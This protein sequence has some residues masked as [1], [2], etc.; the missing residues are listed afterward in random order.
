MHSIFPRFLTSS[1]TISISR[2]VFGVLLTFL[3]ILTVTEAAEKTLPPIPDLTKGGELTRHNAFLVGPAG[4][5]SWI[6][7]PRQRSDDKK[8]IRQFQVEAVD[9]G[10]PADGILAKGD[11]IIGADGSGA[12]TVPLFDRHPE[13]GIADAI[14]EAEARN[15]A[16]LKLLR[17]RKGK[18]ET[19]TLTLET[20]GAYSDTAPYNCPKSKRILQKCVKAFYEANEPGEGGLGILILLAADDP[21]N[22]DSEKYQARAKEWAHKLIVT[23]ID[24]V[25]GGAWQISYTLISLT[26]YYLKTKD[27]EVFPT[28]QFYAQRFAN[29]QSWFGTTGHRFSE[30]QSDGSPNGL[31]AGY[32][33]I[34]AS[35]LAGFL[36]MNLAREAGVKSAEVDAA[37]RRADTFLGSY[38]FRSGIPYG[39]HPFWIDSKSYDNNGKHATAAFA[40]ALQHKRQ[41]EARWYAKMATAASMDRYYAH[42]GPY[43]AQV[44]DPLGAAVGGEKAANHHFNQIRWHLDLNRSWDGTIHYRGKTPYPGWADAA[45]SLLTYA[46]PLR[47]L[48]I[49]G[50]GHRKSFH[51]TD[52]EMA[53]VRATEKFNASSMSSKDLVAALSN[54]A[55]PDR[56][57]AVKELALRAKD[58]AVRSA[59]LTQLHTL[60]ANKKSQ[61]LERA[62]ACYALSTILDVSSTKVLIDRLSDQDRHVR[63]V[64]AKGLLDFPREDVMPHVNTILDLAATSLKPTFPLVEGDPIQFAHGAL[65]ELL[66]DSKKGLLKDS[67]EGIDRD[68]LWAAARAISNT[69]GGKARSSL[70]TLY[71]QLSRE[72]MLE[73]GE[74]IVE[75][76][77]VRAPA[78]SMFAKGIIKAGSELFI[79]HSIAEGVHLAKDSDQVKYLKNYAGSVLA[80]D[81]AEDIIEWLGEMGLVEGQKTSA[82]VDAISNDTNPKALTKMKLIHS[83]T[84]KD[85][86]L[87]LPMNKT[88]LQVK[89]TNYARR[90]M[91]DTTYT[92]RKVYGV[93]E[94][95]FS[96][97]S[98]SDSKSTTV[99]F[100]DL[101]PGEYR[102]EVTMSDTLGYNVVRD[103]VDVTLFDKS[104]QLPV[105]QTPNTRLNTLKAIPGLP[106]SI[107]ILGGN[108]GGV[109]I[110]QEPLHGKVSTIDSKI[111]YVAN[112]GYTGTDS[113]TYKTI[114]AK[115]AS[116]QEMVQRIEVSDSNVGVVVYEG[117]DC[118][119]GVLSGRSGESSLGFVGSWNGVKEF[120][121][122][123]G[124]FSYASL[125]SIGGKIIQ[126]NINRS[127]SRTINPSVIS[128]HALLKDGKELW[129]SV[130][131][132]G[133]KKYSSTNGRI[134]FELKSGDEKSDAEVGFFYRY[135]K[136]YAT[137]NNKNEHEK[138]R[139]RYK[140]ADTKFPKDTPHLV[141]GH[142]VWGETDTDPD[143]IKIYRVFD[144][145]GMGPMLLK[146]PISV[147]KGFVQQAALNGIHLKGR[148]TIFDEIRIGTSYHSV[149]M[150][151]KAIAN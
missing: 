88:A 15:P 102:F 5:N 139:M 96:P 116:K 101:K 134:S 127:I 136:I 74:T 22:P 16:A 35:G 80:D 27:A 113:F 86:T 26:E 122:D 118:K 89:A 41:K 37:I 93:G 19:V 13:Y 149:L 70:G 39:E 23:S 52:E 104:G 79:R 28:I 126:G 83:V 25:P 21:E 24:D 55:L 2:N 46:L 65:A 29:G 115:G 10:S 150:G 1:V 66:F 64:A 60:A 142:C 9:K 121:I 57:K 94:V 20:L 14:N 87:K 147:M 47:Q 3:C 137:M 6:W 73:L 45:T 138:S 51:F 98:S 119:P 77:R 53:S 132:G 78:D 8:H 131:I 54:W 48:Y 84:A 109:L 18:T 17:W 117:F 106:I 130:V 99:E 33:A 63:F 148:D 59:L 61:P 105:S 7:R 120:V 110:T 133:T 100:K 90:D 151:T 92:W 114:T 144:A 97:N 68:K 42:A 103:I 129:F 40:F 107:S 125:P 108:G 112:F 124:S 56:T 12:A 44:F 72:E 111:H 43:F 62:G 30:R 76:V 38:A 140:Q 145:P 69:P 135:G 67:I 85:P 75:S 82:V 146:E 95:S 50:R 58:P 71:K 49:T 36:G 34:N 4:F 32:G 143:T 141:V 123:H 91:K 31:I 81:N 11:V 128:K